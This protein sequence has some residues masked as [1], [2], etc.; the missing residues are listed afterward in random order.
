MFSSGNARLLDGLALMVGG[1]ALG[2]AHGLDIGR[3]ALP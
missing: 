2:V 3:H 1:L